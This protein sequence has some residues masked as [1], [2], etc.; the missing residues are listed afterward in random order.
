M[1]QAA[2]VADAILVVQLLE[3]VG[4]ERR[5]PLRDVLVDRDVQRRA[6]F[7]VAEH[8][9]RQQIPAVRQQPAGVEHRVA[10]RAEIAV[11]EQPVEIAEGVAGI[12]AHGERRLR[13]A[14]LR[15]N[16]HGHVAEP[17]RR[18]RRPEIGLEARIVV[19]VRFG[20]LG[21][22]AIGASLFFERLLQQPGFVEPV[23][24]ARVGARATV[25]R[26]LVVL[27]ALRRA[28]DRR[29]AHVFCRRFIQTFVGFLNNAR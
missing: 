20:E 23:E 4:V 29:V 26:D 18:R 11:G 14:S 9:N 10:H 22:P 5:I 6:P 19:D 17:A 12:V 25:R 8:S 1:Q 21:E 2:L 13:A 27:D 15:D 7:V 3:F 16:V 24:P 28:D